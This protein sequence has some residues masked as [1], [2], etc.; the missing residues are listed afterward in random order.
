MLHVA[1]RM[2]DNN[3]K[4]L[5]VV[6]RVCASPLINKERRRQGIK[7]LHELAQANAALRDTIDR[8][9]EERR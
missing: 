7:Q 1:V 8:E 4:I 3:R 5:Y 2:L 9:I 6:E